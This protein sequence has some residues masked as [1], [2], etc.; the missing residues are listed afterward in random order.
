MLFSFFCAYFGFA[1]L[2]LSKNRH[3]Q[4]V[5]PERK[6]SD[7][8]AQ[9]LTSFGWVLLV[10]SSFPVFFAEKFSIAFTQ[11]FGVLSIAA[12][13]L[14]VQFAYF[15]RSVAAIIWIDSAI[16]LIYRRAATEK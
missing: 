9:I 4:Q 12:F 7:D 10:F 1:A 11:Y 14:I 5:W 6:L 8:S 3:Y 16:K 15:P 2:S 13:F